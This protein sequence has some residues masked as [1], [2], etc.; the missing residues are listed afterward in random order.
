MNFSKQLRL[1]AGS[2]AIGIALSA[3]PAIAQDQETAD[4]TTTSSNAPIIVTGSRIERPNLESASPV[5]VVTAE[6]VTEFADITIDTFLN[7]LPQVNPAG[8]PTSNNPGNGGQSNIDLRGLGANRNIVLIDG[9]RPMVSATNLTVDLNTIPAAL[10]ERIDIITGGAGAVYGADAIS[11]AVNIVLHD[12]FEGVDARVSYSNAMENWDAEEWSASLALGGNFA[13]DRGNAVIGFE[14]SSREALV[15]SQRD[16]SVFATSTTTFFPDGSY[17]DSRNP[18]SQ[19]AV[20]AVFAQY[21]VAAGEVLA[22]NT[23]IAFNPD[24]T[25]FSAGIFNSP[26]DVQNFTGPV[27][28]SVNQ[29]I[30][31]DRYSYNFDEVNLLVLPFERTSLMGKANYEIFPEAEV[32]GQFGY[33]RYTSATALAPTPIPTVGITAIGNNTPQQATS[34]LVEQFLPNGNIAVV[35]N[36]FIVPVTNPF[37]PADLAT[38]LASRTMDDNRLVGSGA[39]E[40]FVMRQRTLDIGLRQSNLTNQVFQLL[41]GV[42]GDLADWLSYE[43]SYSFGRTNI[44][45]LQTGN[46][47][48]QRLQTL[49]EAPDGGDSICQGGFNPFGRQPLSAACVTYL[50]STGLLQTEFTQEIFQGYVVADVAEL[51]AGTLSAVL[52]YEQRNFDF[53]FNPGQAGGPISGFNAQVPAGGTNSFN[54][55]FG[56]LSIP[57]V[58]GQSWAQ[59]LTLT[60]GYRASRSEFED[61]VN[62]VVSD[63]RWDDAFKV[64][65][66]WSPT[67]DINVRGSFQRSVRAPNFGELFSGGGSA[68]QIFDPCSVT[69]NF[70]ADTSTGPGT[71]RRIC[72][73]A[74]S[75]GGLGEAA[76]DAFVQSP[77]TQAQIVTTGNTN[78]SPETADTYTFGVAFSDG[79]GFIPGLS[80]SID[81]YKIDISDTIQVPDSNSVIADCYNFY[82]NNPNLDP[83]YSAC[84]QLFRSGDILFVGGPGGSPFASFPG[85]NGGIVETSGIDMQLAY[86]FNPGITADD[87]L[88]FNLLVNY[89]IDFNLQAL[90]NLPVIDYAGSVSF[91]GA[92]LG[93][94]FPEWKAY[95][96]ANYSTGDIGFQ[97]RTRFIDGMENRAARVFPGED[98]AFTGTDSAI[99]VDTAVS[100][101]VEQFTFRL[102]VNNVF[103][104]APEEYAP[105][106][107]SGTDPSLF[108]VIGRRAFGSVRLRF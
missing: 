75:L 46:V 100:F 90:D 65:L 74:G 105:N 88:N 19:D 34:P 45:N 17:R 25:L 32:F 96:D 10:I 55:I 43:M 59:D 3:N 86:G 50:E 33:T 20:D 56:E 4:D 64:E 66:V 76:V 60:L 48:T 61:V 12:D 44:D 28:F 69:T 2:L 21:G 68:P 40:P 78:L 92:G 49:L 29:S 8:G 79:F 14:Y 80:G 91:F 77:G 30:F 1:G 97:V 81:Y 106:V 22:G 38:L 95:L 15:K 57:I 31:P 24:G 9:R 37:I 54:D 36:E 82:G 108:D 102:G 87:S 53:N 47:D 62:G 101:N 5:Q 63:P 18:P 107:Q 104:R 70:R 99:Y 98:Q 42:R 7:T 6:Q 26:I 67:F 73:D 16:F 93:T 94:S 89:L 71:P 23:L 51:P 84:T 83:T 39:T 11:G 27:D 58:S 72:R 85:V 13:D 52:G 35:S 41:G 103:D